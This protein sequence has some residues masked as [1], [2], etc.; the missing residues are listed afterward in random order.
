MYRGRTFWFTSRDLAPA[1]LI[2]PPSL[3]FP[4]RAARSAG[5]ASFP[6]PPAVSPRHGAER[7]SLSRVASASERSAKPTPKAPLIARLGAVR[8]AAPQ[9]FYAAAPQ[10]SYAAAVSPTRI[11]GG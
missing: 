3:P 6:A 4:A 1:T 5:G 9:P 7:G 8:C 11:P 2:K 10:P